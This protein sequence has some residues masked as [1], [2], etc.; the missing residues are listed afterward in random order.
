MKAILGVSRRHVHLTEETWKII[1]GD[2]PM[3]KRNDLGQPGQYATQHKVDV[4]VGDKKI[5]G[6][7]VIGPFRKYNQVELAQ[8]DADILGINPPRRQSGDLEGSLPITIIGPN[9]KVDLQEG[10]ILAERHI[11]IDPLTAK[12]VGLKD[13]QEMEVYKDDKYLFNAI[14]KEADPAALE[15]HIDTDEASDYNLST[16]DILDIRACGK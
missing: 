14:I 9:G 2:I 5:E 6:L 13:K 10:A 7:R 15:I 4:E 11:H 3:L 8:T 12:R 16:G 1:F